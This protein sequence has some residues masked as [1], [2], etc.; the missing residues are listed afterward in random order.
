LFSRHVFI[1]TEQAELLEVRATSEGHVPPAAVM[2]RHKVCQPD[3][4][5]C[6]TRERDRIG[7]FDSR[8]LISR[9]ALP[10]VLGVYGL[11][12][13]GV[14]RLGLIVV[15]HQVRQPNSSFRPF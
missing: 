12:R 4:S 14:S 7:P 6:C 8:S 15:S 1:A 5:L 10:L 11:V 2:G 13:L 3:V 9:S